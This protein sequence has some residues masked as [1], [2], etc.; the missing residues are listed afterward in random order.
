MDNNE[1]VSALTAV[2]AVF[3]PAAQGVAVAL[4][5]M[6]DGYNSDIAKARADLQPEV[7]AAIAAA[8]APLTA[9]IVDL[10]GQLL[11]AQNA[12][13]TEELAHQ[14]DNTTNEATITDLQT[15]LAAANATIGDLQDTITKLTPS[16]DTPADPAQADATITS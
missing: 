2:N 4:K 12:T 9:Q 10:Q 14:S 16:T 6:Q 7:D 15:K 13:T 3:G 8:T 1:I 11:T 5:V